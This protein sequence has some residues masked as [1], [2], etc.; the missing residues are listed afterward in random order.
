MPFLN[1]LTNI[2]PGIFVFG[3]LVFI[4]EL[5]HF[6]VAKWCGV[7]VEQF[8]VGFGPKL[9]GFQ[10]HGTEYKVAAIPLGG[11]V[12][13]AGDEY[14][15]DGERPDPDTFLG[16]PWWH[17]VLIALA[18][19][20]ANFLL[21]FVVGIL[22]YLVG[23][24]HPNSSNVV[25]RIGGGSPVAEVGF[26][27]NDRIV[28]VDGKP[29]SGGYAIRT[30]LLGGEKAPRLKAPVDVP[31]VVERNGARVPFVVP[32][33]LLASVN[34]SL[35]FFQPAEIGEVASG[36]PAYTAGLMVGD[37]IV[38]V[39]GEP[40]ADWAALTPTVTRMALPDGPGTT[41]QKLTLGIARGEKS[42]TVDVTPMV[43]KEDGEETV[44]IGIG[45]SYTTVTVRYGFGEAVRYGTQDTLWKTGA[46]FQGIF[47]LFTS[48]K[49]I[50]QSVS[51]PV[52]I[53][54][55]SAQT[56]RRGVTPLLNLLV[57]LSL[58][59]MAFNLL[60]IP[61]LD[62]GLVVT[63]VIEGIRRKPIPFRSLL[64]AQR[65]GMVLLGSLIL[66][67][68]LNDPLKIIRRNRAI[69]E[70]KGRSSRTE[71]ANPAPTSSPTGSAAPAGQPDAQ[72]H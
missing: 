6:L 35:R 72:G 59:L 36:S 22:M 67:T 13:M 9:F 65:V 34:D 5:G 29:V 8:S 52:A 56:A 2:L 3:I 10:R 46:T 58:A 24:P 51:G 16:H 41:P 63:A 39:N 7:P 33:A 15:E 57:I 54:E 48:P 21:A 23:I 70:S 17:R 38:S 69:S 30:T 12:K 1:G 28:E 61:I 42:L 31:V 55:M 37:R 53:I 11:F 4:H 32:A 49:S 62:G 64:M 66:F 50:G 40:I 71:P 60:P 26:L 47:G 14:P 25:G 44:R 45:A 43:M 27:E 19:P 20:G 18:G 68:L